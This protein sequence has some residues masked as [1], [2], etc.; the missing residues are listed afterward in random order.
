[1]ATTVGNIDVKT[2]LNTRKMSLHTHT[3]KEAGQVFDT[4]KTR[5]FVFFCFFFISAAL[6]FSNYWQNL[7]EKFG[8]VCTQN[9]KFCNLTCSGLLSIKI[10][11]LRIVTNKKTVAECAAAQGLISS[12]KLIFQSTQSE[13]RDL[14]SGKS[15]LYLIPPDKKKKR[16]KL[17]EQKQKAI[18]ENLTSEACFLIMHAIK[19]CLNGKREKARK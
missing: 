14:N 1:M 4:L 12:C 5:R 15:Y 6:C 11:H 7:E 8:N 13:K 18:I 2:Y 17:Y 10:L 3:K 9:T 19:T 16:R